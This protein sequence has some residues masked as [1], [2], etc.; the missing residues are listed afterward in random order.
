[1]NNVQPP[2]NTPQQQRKPLDLPEA[3]DAILSRWED[4]DEQVSDNETDAAQDSENEETEAALELN[5]ED[6]TEE[7]DLEDETD[8]EQE[9]EEP[10]DNEDDDNEV[11]VI[12]DEAEV[13]ILVDGE[14]HRASVKDLK[15]L[16]G[17]EASLTRKSQ[18]VASQRKE[19]EDALQ[20]GD[21]LLQAM[22]QRAEE[23][24]KPYSEVDMLLASKTMDA[25][26]FAALR[27]EA[28]AASED[29][30]FLQEEADK[31]YGAIKAQQA[32]A[33]KKAASEAIA[34]LKDNIPDWSNETYNNIRQY[35]IAQGLPEE[36][37]NNYV[38]PTVI[39]ILNKARLFDQ[40]KRVATVKKK[41]A[42]QKKVLRSKKSPPDAQVRRN[43]NIEKQRQNLRDNRGAD[44]EDIASALMSR[45][46]S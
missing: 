46:E 25:E 17:Q 3:E 20:K 37:V 42:T 6:E 21:V 36:Q 45:W 12:T 9:D 23:R 33:Q 38:D 13:E 40:G 14:T 11:E 1:M 28:Q 26:D 34:V 16:Y 32:E 29:V 31:Y 44:L 43:A 27:K 22:L 18:Q 7:V 8:P 5:E 39:Q 19:A 4:P 30:K 41:A 2:E 24:Y 10:E 15:R 35:A